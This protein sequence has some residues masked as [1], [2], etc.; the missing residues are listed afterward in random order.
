MDSTGEKSQTLHQRLMQF[1]QCAADYF[2]EASEV[3]CVLT[4][5]REHLFSWIL[6][7]SRVLDVGCGPGDNGY[8]LA[9]SVRYVGLDIS[10]LALRVAREAVTEGIFAA[11]ESHRLPF[12]TGGF[13]AVLS[14]YALEHLVF[15]QASLNEIWRVCRPGGLILLISPAYDDP[16]RLPPSTSHWPAGQR[17]LLILQQFLR[18][19][20]RHFRPNRFRFSCVMRPRIL[21]DEYQSDFD[22][23]HL[24]SAR[25][26]SNFFRAK[27][28]KVVFERKR[29]PRP[30][31]GGPL[32]KRIAEHARNIVLR[33]HLAEY[34]GLNLQIIIQ[35]QGAGPN[36]VSS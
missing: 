10:P 11:G 8:H 34:C 17:R 13:D 9:R 28:A 12:S 23:V 2:V 22:A 26:V 7:G 21:T 5:E 6:P 35:K 19:A 27:G 29:S 24:V 20:A 25:E 4:P 14:T 33:L 1:Y 31:Y 15:A 30:V 16:R 32:K 3:N 18:Q 36:P